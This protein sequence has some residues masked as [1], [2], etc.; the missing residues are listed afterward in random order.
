M[1]LSL[2]EHVNHR[3]LIIEQVTF[4][5]DQKGRKYELSVFENSKILEVANWNFLNSNLSKIPLGRG[6]ESDVRRGRQALGRHFLF[7]NW[8]EMRVS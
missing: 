2:I 4:F 1:L 6:K 5:I 7:S 8:P 3:C